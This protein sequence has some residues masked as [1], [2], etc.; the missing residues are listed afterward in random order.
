MGF[1]PTFWIIIVILDILVS[2]LAPAQSPWRRASSWYQPR[3]SCPSLVEGQELK[4]QLG[5]VSGIASHAHP[6]TSKT[7][8]RACPQSHFWASVETHHLSSVVKRDIG[9]GDSSPMLANGCGKWT[10]GGQS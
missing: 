5:L 6:S 7:S 3:V 2:F 1:S 10:L 9:A 4:S 8:A